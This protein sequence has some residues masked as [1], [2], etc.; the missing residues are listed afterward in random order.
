[1][2]LEGLAVVL[3]L[4]YLYAEDEG[5]ARPDT[6]EMTRVLTTTRGNGHVLTKLAPC[7][8]PYSAIVME[9]AFELK[10][11][12]RSAMV[13]WIL[14]EVNDHADERSNTIYQQVR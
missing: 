9:L 4:K 12:P 3:G 8:Y 13:C 10:T 1:M 2:S 6:I 7:R 14:M 5:E 11:R